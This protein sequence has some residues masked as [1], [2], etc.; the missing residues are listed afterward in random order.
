MCMGIAS[1]KSFSDISQ[2]TLPLCSWPTVFTMGKPS[3][4]SG[5]EYRNA[6]LGALR[7]HS[8][9]ELPPSNL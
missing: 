3:R 6:L 9:P 7:N 4:S 8:S 5:Q 2:D 1:A